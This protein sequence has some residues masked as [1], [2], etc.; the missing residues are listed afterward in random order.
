MEGE[1]D[2]L[3]DQIT[4]TE[5]EDEELQVDLKLLEEVVLK[6][7]CCLL[8]KLHANKLYNI[9]A[10]KL[11]LKK[12]WQPTNV[13]CFLEIGSIILLTIFDNITDKVRLLRES[14]WNF[15]KSLILLKELDGTL[16]LNKI[17]FTKTI[18]WVHVHD[19][20]LMARNEYMRG[21]MG[22]SIGV[23]EEIDLDK[24][25]IEWGEYM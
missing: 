17:R 8:H 14:P 16:Q 11:T 5:L 23:V 20:Q 24:G 22:N 1:V 18:F 7:P 12:I 3:C 19:L 15:E 21:L 9:K 4:L 6:G 13:V 10:F 25:E 2:D